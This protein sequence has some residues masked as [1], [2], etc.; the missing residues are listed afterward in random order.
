MTLVALADLAEGNA[1]HAPVGSVAAG[2]MLLAALPS[3][4]DAPHLHRV[5]Y[6][7]ELFL[8]PY[9]VVGELAVLP[10]FDPG[11]ALTRP[12]SDFVELRSAQVRIATPSGQIEHEYEQISVN[13]FAVERVGCEVDVTFWFPGAA[14]ELPPEE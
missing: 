8:G 12:A 3:D 11:R 6:A 5:Y 14:Q 4:S 9:T 10:G 1:E 2:E 7:V 13:R